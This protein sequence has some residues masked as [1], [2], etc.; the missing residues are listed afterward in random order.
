MFFFR[1]KKLPFL[2]NATPEERR[3]FYI[4]YGEI[5]FRARQEL[6]VSLADIS[7]K[8]GIPE[9]D[10]KKYECGQPVPFIE[11]VAIYQYLGLRQHLENAQQP[12]CVLRTYIMH[13]SCGRCFY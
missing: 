1:K 10:L 13:R 9:R 3:A 4:E 2:A 6:G 5:M 11:G 12:I 8:L 7:S